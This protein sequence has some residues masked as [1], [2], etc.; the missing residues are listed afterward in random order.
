[1]RDISENTAL[2]LLDPDGPFTLTF[3]EF[4]RANEL[5]GEEIAVIAKDLR[6]HGRH[7]GGG[8]AAASFALEVA[9]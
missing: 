5:T 7:E 6:E 1:M 9:Q 8:G 4:L 2:R 3:G